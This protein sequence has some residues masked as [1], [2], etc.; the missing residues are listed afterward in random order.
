MRIGILGS[1]LMGSKLGTIIARAGHN[2]VFSYSRSCQKLERLAKDAGNNAH[3]GTAAEASR[4]AVLLAVHWTRVDDGLTQA[5][6]LSGKA[7]LTCSLPMSKDDTHMVIGH[8]TSGAETLAAKVPGAHV[9]SAF[10]TVPSEVLFPVFERRRKGTPP[11]LIY[12]GDDEGAKKTAAGLIR[13][14]GF[15]PVDLGALSCAR[16]IEPFSWVVAQIAYNI[17]DGPEL[18]YRF[19][20]LG[21]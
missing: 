2:V 13:D 6:A 11:D 5:G 21:K 1:G 12:C 15:N 7:L 17:S 20:R 18:A 4:D 9:V 10:S 19:E 8:T 16:Y 3:V 14:A